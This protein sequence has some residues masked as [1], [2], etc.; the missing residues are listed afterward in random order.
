MAQV[1]SVEIVKTVKRMA[2]G[3]AQFGVRE[4]LTTLLFHCD[5]MTKVGFWVIVEHLDV[6]VGRAQLLFSLGGPSEHSV[7]V[8]ILHLHSLSGHVHVGSELFFV[9]RRFFF[10][11]DHSAGLCVLVEGDITESLVVSFAHEFEGG[12]TFPFEVFGDLLTGFATAF[13]LAAHAFINKKVLC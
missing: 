8:L 2:N 3:I 11:H 9:A 13:V 7:E 1:L 12:L 10:A 5:F 4:G 6:M